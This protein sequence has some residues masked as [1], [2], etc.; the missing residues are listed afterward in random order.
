MI[1]QVKSV[2][3]KDKGLWRWESMRNCSK[4]TQG[5]LDRVLVTDFTSFTI[6]LWTNRHERV[7]ERSSSIETGK[8]KRV[9]NI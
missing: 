5:K 9:K 1:R 3:P 6:F 2:I 8:G 4:D 7:I